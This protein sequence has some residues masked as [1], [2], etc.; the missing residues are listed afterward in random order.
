[1][2]PFLILLSTDTLLSS[3]T[4]NART[5]WASDAAS[6]TGLR[7]TPPLPCFFSSNTPSS[8]V[9]LAVVR[10]K[11]SVYPTFPAYALSPLCSLFSFVAVDRDRR[12]VLVYRQLLDPLSPLKSP[13]YIF[14]LFSLPLIRAVV[15]Y[16][17]LSRTIRV[18]PLFLPEYEASLF[19]PTRCTCRTMYVEASLL[20]LL[21]VSLPY[22]NLLLCLVVLS[23][24]FPVT[25]HA[26]CTLPAR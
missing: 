9:F 17:S 1:M 21:M 10:T 4:F 2:G 5:R 20:P 19:L 18:S 14:S 25:I 11:K 12:N 13:Q 23:F 6:K 15:F 8:F 22:L 26:T 24:F 7:R 3:R 16:Y